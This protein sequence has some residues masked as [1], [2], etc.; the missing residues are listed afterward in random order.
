MKLMKKL[1]V[2]TGF[3]K[4]QLLA[5]IV[6]FA[7]IGGFILLKS[8]AA[9]GAA[10]VFVAANGSDS[11]ANCKRFATAQTNP[12]PGGTSLCASFNK[13]LQLAQ[14]GDNVEVE[15]GTYGPQHITAVPA[16]SS[17]L[18]T[19]AP[20]Q[21]ASVTI[22]NGG[23]NTCAGSSTTG[24]Q[25]CIED[26][27]YFEL[28]NMAL[29]AGAKIKLVNTDPSHIGTHNV[30]LKNLTATTIRMY[31]WMDTI[32]VIGG[33]YGNND[34]SSK[35]QVSW[36]N[37]PSDPASAAPTNVTID[38][39][40][41]HDT[42]CTDGQHCATTDHAECL[43]ILRSVNLVIKNSTFYNC[44]GTGDIGIT[45]GPHT[46]LLMEN[47]FIAKGSMPSTYG[48]QI[49]KNGSYTIRN[50]SADISCFFSDT[51]AGGPYVVTGNYM[52]YH[53]SL[54][55]AGITTDYNVFKGSSTCGSH[56]QAVAT[57]DFVDAANH[58]F[59]LAASANAIDKGNP[60]NCPATDI[61]GD[62]RPQGTACDA[63]ADEYVP[64]VGSLANIW[65]DTNGGTCTR[66]ATPAAYNDAAACSS[67]DAANDK[68][69][70]NDVALV[71]AGSYTDQN[72]TGSNSRTAACTIQ[73]AA[74]EVVNFHSLTMAGDW[75]TIKDMTDRS[76]I[77]E[78]NGN[79]D[80][81]FTGVC[82]TGNHITA[83]NIDVL[84]KWAY[85]NFKGNNNTW[86]NSEMGT[87]GN[88]SPRLCGE[89]PEPVQMSNAVNALIKNNVFHAFRGEEV[90]ANCGGNDVYHLET[91]R[92][93]DTSDG[94]TFLNNHF[95]DGN[96]DDSFTIF[97]GRGGCP[98]SECPEN[99]NVHIIGN[100]FG[101]KC[102]SY[103]AP[104]VGYGD[105]QSCVGQGWVFAYNFFHNGD[106]G[107]GNYCTSE[108]GT[109][110]VGNMGYN[111]GGCPAVGTV[112]NNLWIGS[113][114]GSCPGNTWLSGGGRPMGKL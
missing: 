89:D 112:T 56:D 91:F 101:E 98:A 71:K 19:F 49:T 94:V 36:Y 47:N 62:S 24:Y 93:W 60:S 39:V 4:P 77:N 20:A 75:L 11:G 34:E 50:N 86:Q 74:S 76:G 5:F 110:Y 78:H 6:V 59:H 87:A 79:S 61:D 2:K 53:S 58:N 83:D 64:P 35:P 82:F 107:L 12:D 96:G 100:Y 65:I 51:D 29:A 102:C 9:G 108:S 26:G 16:G 44:D 40:T 111:A 99:I 18:V 25:L 37:G 70:N 42:V 69:Q 72:I 27:S 48:C 67:L 104:D 73:A 57:L 109:I 92:I 106:G 43:Q 97:S 68:C 3:S 28:D 45:D 17:G 32:S 54:C 90:E 21:G 85:V 30:T 103:A 31:G 105:G 23:A 38:G 88:T 113:S 81:C 15:N 66:S 52:P 1:M 33:N 22:G 84:G 7:C 80:T 14:R 63:G 55:G 41:F 10:N 114:H 95:D 8:N 13:V 46:N